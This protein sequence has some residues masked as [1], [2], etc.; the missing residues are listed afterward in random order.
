MTVF[1]GREKKRKIKGFV[2]QIETKKAFYY[3]NVCKILKVLITSCLLLSTLII[4]VNPRH[5][6]IQIL[7]WICKENTNE[8]YDHDPNTKEMQIVLVA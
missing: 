1:K 3:P 5:K 6:E 2:E 8:N 7:I 4:K